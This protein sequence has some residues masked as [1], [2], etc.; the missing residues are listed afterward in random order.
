[1]PSQSPRLPSSGLRGLTRGARGSAPRAW[2]EEEWLAE[3]RRQ[4]GAYSRREEG[5]NGRA[6]GEGKGEEVRGPVTVG[7]AGSARPRWSAPASASCARPLP[8]APRPSTPRTAGP[9]VDRALSLLLPLREEGA[10]AHWH[11]QAQTAEVKRRPSGP[12]RKGSGWVRSA[13][14]GG[15]AGPVARPGP[16]CPVEVPR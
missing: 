13:P 7:P 14:G 8:A 6:V 3:R 1:M 10:H 4:A 5:A 11:A 15:R 9:A 12:P 2:G 16:T